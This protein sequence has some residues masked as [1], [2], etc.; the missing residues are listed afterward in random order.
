MA[1]GSQTRKLIAAALALAGC[2]LLSL[3]DSVAAGCAALLVIVAL[4]ASIIGSMPRVRRILLISAMPI[5]VLGNAVVFALGAFVVL[6]GSQ[7]LLD[8]GR[9]GDGPQW[10]WGFALVPAAALVNLVW[11]AWPTSAARRPRAIWLMNLSSA[12]YAIGYWRAERGQAELETFSLPVEATL[13]IVLTAL[14]LMMLTFEAAAGA[15]QVSTRT[16]RVWRCTMVSTFAVLICAA[17]GLAAFPAY[18]KRQVARELEQF[19]LWANFGA[20]APHW[21][22][23]SD[24]RFD[25]YDYLG[26]INGASAPELL[27]GDAGQAASLLNSLPWLQFL[28][29]NELPAEGERI[30]RPV[31]GHARLRT[32]ALKGPG[33]TDAAL[34]DAAQ[35]PALNRAVFERSRI[36]D[37]GLANLRAASWLQVLMICKTPITGDGLV[38]L[39]SLPRL[40]DLNL[41]GTSF[42]DRQVA[43][44]PQFNSLISLWLIDTQVTDSGL[45][46]LR[47]CK[48]LKT[49]HLSGSRVTLEGVERLR[50]ALP[51]CNVMWNQWRD[52]K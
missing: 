45:T 9:I 33:V 48:K 22:L 14:S 3:W 40:T 8:Q 23:P 17:I 25:W 5:A 47:Q 16:R 31:A 34:V 36:T 10:S 18:H 4:A 21:Y 11:L 27:N 41:S 39:V 7:G 2:R 51:N 30:L 44:L 37:D 20:I 52:D 15:S 42:G 43:L 13:L 32:V 46:T 29:V 19:G 38:H 28:I 35:L 26:E 6:L 50:R 12:I 24:I 1:A 49:V